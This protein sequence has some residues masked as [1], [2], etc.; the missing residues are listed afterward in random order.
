MDAHVTLAVHVDI[1][2]GPLRLRGVFTRPR[3]ARGVVLFA[4]GS[5][6]GRLSPRNQFVAATLQHA[7]F[8]TLLFDLLTA[9]EEWRER[10]TR[11][12]RFDIPLLAA[13][14]VAV[15]AWL[16]ARHE[17]ADLP[18]GYFGASTGA[19]AALVAAAE[20]ASGEHR[21]LPRIHAVVSRGGRPDLADGALEL[22]LAPTL[23]IVGAD[24]HGVIEL[25]REALARLHCKKELTLVPD[26]THLFEEPGTL[27]VAARLAAEWFARYLGGGG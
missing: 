23:L 24:D 2:L 10:D 14:L 5:G 27:A 18:V 3:D 16:H 15:T 6:S 22:V 17:A 9:D 12:L 8:A 21:H 25:N 19:A 13:R 26:A 1:D 7:G 4:H 11:H 20:A